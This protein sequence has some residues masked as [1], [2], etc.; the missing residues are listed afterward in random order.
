[1]DS[2][3]HNKSTVV[4]CRSYAELLNMDKAKIMNLFH[5]LVN[6]ELS[7]PWKLSEKI[8]KGHIL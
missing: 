7:G 5:K 1:M 3:S 8:L 2:Y 4:P 6:K